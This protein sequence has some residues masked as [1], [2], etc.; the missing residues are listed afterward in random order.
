M[1]REKKIPRPK[2]IQ[3]WIDIFA[4]PADVQAIML[5][6]TVRSSKANSTIR[7]TAPPSPIVRSGAIRLHS[8]RSLTRPCPPDAQACCVSGRRGG[9]PGTS[10]SDVS[11]DFDMLVAFGSEVAVTQR[12]NA[13]FAKVAP[14]LAKRPSRLKAPA[15]KA[16][17]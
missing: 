17:I 12:A 5:T 9:D 8:I 2:A 1:A 13:D 4:S 14:P 11:D 10:R 16:A 7:M 15:P 6:T 3:P